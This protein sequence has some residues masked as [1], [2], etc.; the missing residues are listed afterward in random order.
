MKARTGNSRK[1]L[2][3]CLKKARLCK[4]LEPP[5]ILAM[6]KEQVKPFSTGC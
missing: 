4:M 1:R 3:V 2:F 6:S 5:G